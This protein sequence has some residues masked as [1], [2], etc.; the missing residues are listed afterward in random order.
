MDSVESNKTIIAG[1]FAAFV[2]LEKWISVDNEYSIV[3]HLF[4]CLFQ[5]NAHTQGATIPFAFATGEIVG[6][7]RISSFFQHHKE[8]LDCC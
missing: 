6:I 8:C 5:T 2:A 3:L 4:A 1:K 7:P